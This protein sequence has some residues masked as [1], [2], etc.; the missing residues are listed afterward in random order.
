MYDALVTIFTC[1]EPV[2]FFSEYTVVMHGV[3][4]AVGSALPQRA[5]KAVT[6]KRPQ[7]VLF[8]FKN[9]FQK[10]K[11]HKISV[12]GTPLTV[13]H[14]R[15]GQVDG[16]GQDMH[17]VLDAC[18]HRGASLA[19]GTTDGRGIVCPYHSM[20]VS[21]DSHPDRHFDHAA[22]Q[23]L[24]WLDYA[25]G[26]LTQHHSPP[27]YPEFDDRAFRTFEYS[28][29]LSV[30]PVLMTENTLDWQHLASVH[31]VHFVKGNPQV[32]IKSTGPHGLATYQ[33]GSELFD[34]IIENEYH[35]PFTTS[36]R[37][38]FTDKRTGRALPPLLLWFSLTP[39]R[40]GETVLHLRV[41]RA[42][43]REVPWITDWIFRLIDELPLIEDAEIVGQ[44]DPSQWSS[45]RLTPGDA[46]VQAYRDAM[47]DAFPEVLD[48]YVD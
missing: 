20:T 29:R 39:A 12:H 34:L 27:V 22:M 21:I 17:I 18:P 9:T 16:D 26:L 15:T 5:L 13:Y 41:S 37:F 6:T 36:L 10:S 4:T 8:G 30:N 11:L 32:T 43:L 42:V 28:K 38:R 47:R 35:I 19:C 44:V 1:N 46:F 7:W 23:G 48:Y 3:T 14:G 45:N 40:R 2:P 33:Y 24:V 25:S 31:R